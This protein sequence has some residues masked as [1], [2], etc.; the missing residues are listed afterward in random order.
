MHPHTQKL[1]APQQTIPHLHFGPTPV[2]LPTITWRA[3]SRISATITTATVAKHFS[4]HH[5]VSLHPYHD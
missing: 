5:C 4:F 1:S 3:Y 2:I